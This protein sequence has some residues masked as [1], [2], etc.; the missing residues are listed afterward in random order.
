MR[1]SRRQSVAA[2]GRA[3]PRPGRRERADR[4]D[5]RRQR[6]GRQAARP[7][8]TTVRQ[9]TCGASPAGGEPRPKADRR[10]G[11]G[12]RRSNPRAADQRGRG[13]VPGGRPP[14]AA[15]MFARSAALSRERTARVVGRGGDWTR[16]AGRGAEAAP[17]AMRRRSTCSAGPRNRGTRARRVQRAVSDSAAHRAAA[18][19]RRGRRDRA[20]P[21]P[22]PRARAGRGRPACAC[23]ASPTPPSSTR[24]RAGTRPSTGPG[25]PYC[26]RGAA[27]QRCGRG[28]LPRP[29]RCG[30]G[31]WRY[32]AVAVDALNPLF[33][34]P[35][36]SPSRGSGDRSS[37]RPGGTA[38]R[39]PRTPRCIR[40][41]R[42]RRHARASP[43]ATTMRWR[44]SGGRSRCVPSTRPRGSTSGSCSSAAACCARPPRR[45]RSAAA[46]GSIPTC[47][48]PARARH[49]RAPVLH[50]TSTCPSRCRR[51]WD[52]ASSQQQTPA[53]GHRGGP[54]PA[55]RP[56]GGQGGRRARPA[57]RRVEVARGGARRARTPAAA[58]SRASRPRPWPSPRRRGLPLAGDRGDDGAAGLDAARRSACSPWSTLVMRA[59]VLAAR[60]LGVTLV[61]R[62]WRPALAVA[63]RRRARRAS[64]G[65]AAGGRDRSPG[66]APAP[67]RAR[68]SP[69][70]AGS[71]C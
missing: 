35:R 68:S 62:G 37:A 25:A 1:G 5:A 20:R 19:V 11:R 39:W 65:A 53:A 51:E 28:D 10:V 60:R 50:R 43:A 22:V 24:R 66:A 31:A 36:A 58:R 56:A 57:R 13:R 41:E 6:A 12:P 26:R 38:A 3:M 9:K 7:G 32:R 18:S 47:R 69:R 29:R 70:R 23:A 61:Q 40:L 14:A 30:R 55:A 21:R 17:G 4:C 16:Q 63:S 54:A 49:R 46:F 52:F 2:G 34:R 42:P 64:V 27:Q 48:A 45:A 15:R 44:R 59:R 8:C 67:R 33:L 71:S